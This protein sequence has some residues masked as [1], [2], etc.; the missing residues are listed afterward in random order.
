MGHGNFSTTFND[1]NAVASRPGFL[2]ARRRRPGAAS[3]GAGD[4]AFPPPTSPM[5]LH[6][7]PEAAKPAATASRPKVDLK[8]SRLSKLLGFHLRL[9]QVALFRDFVATVG[10][11]NLTPKQY[12]VLELIAENP[13]VSQVD[14]AATLSMDRATMM[15]LVDRLEA[16]SLLVRQVSKT[17]R[18][19]QDL[20]LTSDGDD[21]LQK[22]RSAIS[23]HE[24]R[25]LADWTPEEVKAA[26]AM[27]RRLQQSSLS[28]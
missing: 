20:H 5:K 12:T 14:L 28:A 18:R 25:I 26:I 9:A 6:A 19:R 27:L 4:D 10:E 16:R 22:A 2:Y 24:A 7:M 15:A 11:L 17:D 21:L 3:A 23:A 8:S 13:G 1:A